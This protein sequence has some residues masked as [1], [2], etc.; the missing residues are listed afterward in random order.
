LTV[1]VNAWFEVVPQLFVWTTVAVQEAVGVKVCSREVPDVPHP[2]H[3]QLP[4]DAGSGLRVTCVPE[5]ALAL[6][7]WVRV[8]L[9]E[10]YA[11]IGVALQTAAGGGGGGVEDPPPPPQPDSVMSAAI[12]AS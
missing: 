9:T 12:A 4:P 3:D 11:V 8:P 2:L 1:T 7:D 5:F 10:V 6:A